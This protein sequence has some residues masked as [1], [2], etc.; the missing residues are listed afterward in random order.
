MKKYPIYILLTAIL[1]A[2]CDGAL[3]QVVT[4]D[5]PEHESQIAIN[6]HFAQDEFFLNLLVAQSRGILDTANY[7]SLQDAK[8]KLFHENNLLFDFEYNDEIDR[9]YKEN[10]SPLPEGNYRLEISHPDYKSVMV[11][12]EMPKAV[13][14]VSVD[15]NKEGTLSPDGE[16]VDELQIVIDD[17]ASEDNFYSIQA[18]I[19]YSYQGDT[20]VYS[21][22]IYLDS[23][24]PIV[25]YSEDGPIFSDGTFN[26]RKQTLLFF[27]YNYFGEEAEFKKIDI[28]VQTLTEDR[29][30]YL[31]SLDAYYN[32]DGNPF[33][34]PVVVHNNVEN[35]FGIFSLGNRNR[36]TFEF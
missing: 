12:Q 18:E 19:Y 22:R 24:D 33:A 13:P 34:E 9:F 7:K 29:F 31:R 2:S 26:G 27:N 10:T 3:E 21:N 35:G 14:V 5:I 16:R 28:F 25:S 1:F 8:V 4:L 32:A 11:T 23:N 6:G 17:P 15:Y 36:F 30:L 20:T